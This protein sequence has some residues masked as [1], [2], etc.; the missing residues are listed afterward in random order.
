MT[1]KRK[2]L[3]GFTVQLFTGTIQEARAKV[4]LTWDGFIAACEGVG[5]V[6]CCLFPSGQCRVDSGNGTF[7]E[8]N[9]DRGEKADAAFVE[10]Q[11]FID[12]YNG[13]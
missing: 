7:R 6:T 10:L 2:D 4:D 11:R 12:T 9:W 5:V 1:L 3:N 8:I 13:K